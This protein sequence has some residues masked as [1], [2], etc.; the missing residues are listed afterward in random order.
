MDKYSSEAIDA[1]FEG[2]DDVR[3]L[4]RSAPATATMTNTPTPSVATSTGSPWNT[5]EIRHGDLGM[6]RRVMPFT[7]H[8]PSARWFS[9][10][11]SSRTDGFRFPTDSASARR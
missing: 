4:P 2:Y 1:N 6:Q 11:P 9:A 5:P 8:V 3:A 10:T 7:S